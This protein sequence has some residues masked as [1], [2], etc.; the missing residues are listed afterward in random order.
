FEPYPSDIAANFLF[1]VLLSYAVVSGHLLETPRQM[2]R[3]VSLSAMALILALCF[4]A[5]FVFVREGLKLP[6]DVSL[7]LAALG[8]AVFGAAV[9]APLR[10]SLTVHLTRFLFPHTYRYK[11]TLSKLS[12][13]DGSLAGW[14]KGVVQALD[15]IAGATHAEKIALLLRNDDTGYYEAKHAAGH[16]W[17]ALLDLKLSVH[18]PLAALLEG[19]GAVLDVRAGNPHAALG[20]VSSPERESLREAGITFFCGVNDGDGLAAVLALKCELDGGWYRHEDEEFLRLACN[21]IAPNIRNEITYAGM[22]MKAITDEVTGFFNHRYFLERLEEET[23]R[24]LRYTQQFA[25]LLCDVD[26]F[27]FLNDTYGHRAGDVALRS[28]AMHM[29]KSLRETDLAFRYGGDEFAVI[30]PNTEAQGATAVAER[31]RQGILNAAA[32]VPG[33]SQARITLSVGIAS[34]LLDGITGNQI[35]DE[36]DTALRRAKKEGGD[37]CCIAS[38]LTPG[39]LAKD[40]ALQAQLTSREDVSPADCRIF[41]GARAFVSIV[42]AKAPHFH[43]HSDRVARYAVAIGTNMGLTDTEI[44][45]LRDAALLHDIGNIAIP[46]AT[47]QQPSPAPELEA[48]IRRHP[49][50]GARIVARLPGLQHLA[51]GVLYHHERLDGSGYPERLTRDSIPLQARIVAVA[52]VYETMTAQHLYRQHLSHEQAVAELK[53]EAGHLLDARAVQSFLDTFP[54]SE[55]PLP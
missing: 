50:V 27:K 12:N 43:G 1:A 34:F 54:N 17:S 9:S 14:G 48:L 2:P 28:I 8:T 25:L 46:E 19:K 45:N 53:R 24:A 35:I 32:F 5:A 3:L 10:T 42:E 30:L 23:G 51:T 36:A 31:M 49:A 44:T 26:S 11:Q 16:D 6:G 52:D 4:A 13:V 41:Q 47:L 15:M 20:D 40:V 29:R 55:P 22:V 18:S 7:L 33:V 37:R 39:E 38:G 21:R